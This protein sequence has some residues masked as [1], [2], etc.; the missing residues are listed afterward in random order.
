MTPETSAFRTSDRG[1]TPVVSKTLALGLTVL[2]IAGMMTV[3]FGG[4]VSD[5][6]TR[7]GSELAERVLATAAGEIEQAPSSVGGT[8]ETQTTIELPGTIAN[9]GYTLVLWNRSDRLVLEHPDPDIEAE[10]SLSLPPNVTAEN[11]TVESGQ[12]LTITV[13]GPTTDRRLTIKEGDR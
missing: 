11:V 4:V 3:L 9:S 7:T 8:V 2:Y 12:S 5:Y 10:T 1:T 6:E 13:R